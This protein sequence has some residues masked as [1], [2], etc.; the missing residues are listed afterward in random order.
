M[1]MLEVCIDS[2]AGLEAC[3]A[4]GA[5]NIELCSALALGGLTPS[6]GMMGLAG[7]TSL[8]TFA[9]IRPRSGNFI[10][11]RN[12]IALM[13]DDISAAADAGLD[14]V[15]MGV[16]DEKGALNVAALSRLCKSAGAMGKTLHRIIDTL[17]DPLT[18]LE[19]AIDLGFDRVLSSGGAESVEHGLNVLSELHSQAAG[20]IEILA[21]SGLTPS[22][23]VPI[24][25]E[26]GV[27]S[28]HCSCSRRT[29][30][31]PK[32]HSL[33]FTSDAVGETDAERIKQY[34]SEV[35]QVAVHT[36]KDAS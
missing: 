2:A 35:A 28:F 12:E 5:K 3:E 6:A 25:K 36:K 31:D 29:P 8:S 24:Y 9:M 17:D 34:L 22:L 33:G 15:V 14:G 7:K 4:A 21:G 23:I 27:T 20:R 11:D 32:L 19:Q 26:T 13:C 30:A 16:A 10:F 18:G 1:A